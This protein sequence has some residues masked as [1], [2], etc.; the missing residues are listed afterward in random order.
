MYLQLTLTHALLWAVFT[1]LVFIGSIAF[2]KLNKLHKD[3]PQEI[4][5]RFKLVSLITIF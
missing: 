2:F 4:I 5:R 3:D 1:P